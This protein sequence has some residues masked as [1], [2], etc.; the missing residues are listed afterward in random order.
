MIPVRVFASNVS[1][2][3]LWRE[4]AHTFRVVTPGTRSCLISGYDFVLA[5]QELAEIL[6]A[7][8]LGQISSVDA[9]VIR[10]STGERWSSHVELVVERNI[11]VESLPLSDFDDGLAWCFRRSG[12]FVHPR[13]AGVLRASSFPIVFSNGFEGY[14]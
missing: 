4:R 14:G 5:Q 1:A 3:T 8:T 13:V 10:H 2:P 12:L 6:V 11:E 9:L 7:E